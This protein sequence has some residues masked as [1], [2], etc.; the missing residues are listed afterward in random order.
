MD[1]RAGQ[2]A[3]PPSRFAI[4]GCAAG[5]AATHLQ[6]LAQVPDAQIVGMSD[7]NVE[8]GTARAAEHSCPFFTSHHALLLETRPDIV[9]VLTPHPFH[10]PIAIDCL[11][12]GAHVLVEKPMAVEVADAD[13][14]NEAAD[15]TGRILAV[16]FQQRFRPVI[17]R[18][19]ALI[20]AGEI[21]A[22][23]RTLCLEPWY[24]PA[25]YYRSAAWRGTWA[26]EGGGVL[27]NQA[28][29]T[30]D[31]F[32]H[33][34]GMP[35]TVWGWTRTQS[36]AIECEDS[37]QAMLEYGNGAPGYLAISTVEA[38]M[39][40]RVQV[41][42]DRG[43]LEITGSQLTVYRFEPSLQEHMASSTEMFGAP[44]VETETLDI[45]GDGGGHLAVY[46]DLLEAI[47]SGRRP[48]CDGREALMSLELANAII[49]SSLSNQ[50]VSLP[51]DRAAYSELLA[52]LRAGRRVQPGRPSPATKP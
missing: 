5:I 44:R 16:N 52:D 8:R 10:A 7:I 15:A 13:R 2:P 49:L 4:I 47:A 30:L 9:V 21:G 38:G 18:A 45:P 3:T 40:G 29:H 25:A 37:A 35:T 42:G 50:R 39:K 1:I 28:P 41:I 26:G 51:L 23:V 31:I 12:A 46:Q 11:Q 19:R 36:H 22:I 14:M 24:R 20:E 32:C 33:L 34:A 48:R 6:A 43:G 27:M 17:E